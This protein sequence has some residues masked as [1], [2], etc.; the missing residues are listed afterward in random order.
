M[1]CEDFD[2]SWDGL[3]KPATQDAGLAHPISRSK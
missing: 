3:S 1:K 2:P